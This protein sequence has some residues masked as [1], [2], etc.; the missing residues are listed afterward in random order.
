MT[1]QREKKEAIETDGEKEIK[2]E[3]KNQTRKIRKI[4]QQRK[5]AGKLKVKN[6]L[7]TK[8]KRKRKVIS[9]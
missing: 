5:D 7:E 1:K 4:M 6:K 8:K 2:E 3:K 9:R